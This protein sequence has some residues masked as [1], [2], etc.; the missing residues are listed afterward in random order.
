[1]FELRGAARDR[2][3][4]AKLPQVAKDRL[5]TQ[6]ATAGADRLTE[7]AVGEMIKAEG[8]YIARMTESGAV[9]VPLF[10]EGSIQVGDRSLT[11]R[12]MLDAFW[13]PQAQGSRSGAVHQ[14]VLHRDDGRSPG[15]RPRARLRPL[16]PGRVARLRYAGPGAG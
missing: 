15:H 2:I 7:A 13:G 11:M 3:A 1:M 10:G 12:E 8:D 14:G 9:R 4:A 16:A 5:Q 6:I